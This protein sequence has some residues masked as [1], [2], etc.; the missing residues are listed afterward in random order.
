[1]PAYSIRAF[2]GHDQEAA[3]LL[4]L[5][6]LGEHFGFIDE[7]MN[8]DVDDI[9]RTYLQR[10]FPFIVAEY[11]GM[12]IGTAG[13]IFNGSSARMV[14]VSVHSDYRRQGIGTALVEYLLAVAR[15]RGMREIWV[16]TTTGW[17][18]AI[19]LYERCGFV[20]FDSDEQH[21]Y[22]KIQLASPDSKSD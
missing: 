5:E 11:A 10:N 19:G 20:C 6:G 3:R 14:R 13:L 8:P 7:T 21:T 17:Q 2:D 12:L 9:A 18:D 1:M 16:E 22:L 4:I 15:Q